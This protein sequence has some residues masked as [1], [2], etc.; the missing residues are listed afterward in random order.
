MLRSEFQGKCEVLFASH[1][2]QGGTLRMKSFNCI[3]HCSLWRYLNYGLWCRFLEVEVPDQ[4]FP[5]KN[6]T[7]ELKSRARG[8]LLKSAAP[9]AAV[10][11]ALSVG[12]WLGVQRLG[13]K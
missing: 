9:M 6:S 1:L 3:S 13:A 10:V 11:V 2:H 5:R 8:S 4:P 7:K 12:L